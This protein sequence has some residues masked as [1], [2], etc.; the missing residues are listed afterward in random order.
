MS[1]NVKRMFKNIENTWVLRIFVRGEMT[2]K[3]GIIEGFKRDFCVE[4]RC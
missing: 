4:G 1:L 3:L 2:K